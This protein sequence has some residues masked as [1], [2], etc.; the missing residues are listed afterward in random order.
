MSKAGIIHFADYLLIS[1]F[2]CVKCKKKKLYKL[3]AKLT[4]F[5]LQKSL[6][7]YLDKGLQVNQCDCMASSFQQGSVGLAVLSSEDPT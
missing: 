3:Q 4:T 7:S 6:I 2:F 1:I 5:P